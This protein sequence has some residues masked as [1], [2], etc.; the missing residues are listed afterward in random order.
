M[1]A[2]VV[3]WLGDVVHTET[4]DTCRRGRGVKRGEAV[5][6]GRIAASE[7]GGRATG[8][9]KRKVCYSSTLRAGWGR[10][11]GRRNL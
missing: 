7:R 9:L 4:H 11:C 5:A 1:G 6:C 2:I 10:G 3:G 8:T